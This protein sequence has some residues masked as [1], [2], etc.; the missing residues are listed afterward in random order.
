[1]TV[2]FVNEKQVR[3]PVAGAFWRERAVVHALLPH[4]DVQHVGGTAIPGSLTKGDLDLQARVPA[5]AF[6]GA[7]AILARHY[8]RNDG[9]TRVP[10]AFAAFVSH[11]GI[12]EVGIQLTAAGGALDVFWRYREA[13]RASPALR[14]ELDALKRA[15]AGC[16][17][18][19]YRE[20]KA[21]FFDRVSRTAEFAAA[22]LP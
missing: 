10:G 1:M 7:E 6:P 11:R 19:A 4:A 2:H 12:V 17:M 16:A 21:A 8:R 18:G 15:H 14:E 20:A 3:A 22:R 5:E 13:L 9:S